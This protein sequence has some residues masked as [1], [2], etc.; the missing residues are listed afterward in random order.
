MAPLPRPRLTAPLPAALLGMLAL[1]ALVEAG[2]G[3]GDRFRSDRAASWAFARRAVVA[4]PLDGAIVCLGDSMVKFGVLPAVLGPR[5]G[6]PAWNLALFDGPPAASLALLSDLLT[7][8]QRPGLLLLNAMPHQLARPAAAPELAT[9][10]PALLSVPEAVGLAWRLGEP[11]LAA[12]T[13]VGRVLPS[14]AARGEI[15]AVVAAALRGEAR[16]TRNVIRLYQRNWQANAGAHVLPGADLPAAIDPSNA[17]LYPADWRPDPH[18]L[19]AVRALL[20]RAATARVPVVWVISPL[21]PEAQARR[22]RLGLEDPYTRVVRALV[23]DDPNVTVVDARPWSTDGTLFADAVHLNGPGA[24]AFSAVLADA[25][26]DGSGHVGRWRTLAPDRTI[27]RRR[28]RSAEDLDA[29]RMALG[30]RG[31]SVRR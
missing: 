7:R 19:A 13:L 22:D 9:A 25:I 8:G 16:S 29:S 14:V 30:G 5:I 18:A 27:A 21:H 28:L 31:G 23:A 15:R 11:T 1:V 2:L 3:R 20:D 12:A 6:R 4:Q 24:E 10:W 26:A 17:G